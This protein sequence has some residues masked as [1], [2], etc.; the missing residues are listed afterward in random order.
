[1]TNQIAE[2]VTMP[3]EKKNFKNYLKCAGYQPNKS[4]ERKSYKYAGYKRNDTVEENFKNVQ[5]ANIII[6]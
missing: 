4:N 1:M 5:D 2:V 6:Q 3:S